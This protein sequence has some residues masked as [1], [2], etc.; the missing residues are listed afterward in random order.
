MDDLGDIRLRPPGQPGDLTLA[1]TDL[2]QHAEQRAEVVGNQQWLQIRSGPHCRVD[3]V[4]SPGVVVIWVAHRHRFPSVRVIG[5]TSPTA[6]YGSPDGTKTAVTSASAGF[7][8]S[9]LACAPLL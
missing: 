5:A 3:R 2:T 4:V 9:S 7:L 8:E 1:D 6:W